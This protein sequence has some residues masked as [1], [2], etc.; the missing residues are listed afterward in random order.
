MSN[1]TVPLPGESPL[2]PYVRDIDPVAFAL[3]HVRTSLIWIEEHR[4]LFEATRSSDPETAERELRYLAQC[5][6]DALRHIGRLTELML[7][8]Y[9][10]DPA[11]RLP[12]DLARIAPSKS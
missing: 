9:K 5:T 4:A 8:G 11:K 3:S 12:R 1:P 2:D 10:I 6:H 7:A